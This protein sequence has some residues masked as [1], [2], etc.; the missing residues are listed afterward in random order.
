[1]ASTS[2]SSRSRASTLGADGSIPNLSEAVA[3]DTTS[4][5]TIT[6]T[7]VTATPTTSSPGATGGPRPVLSAVEPDDGTLKC[8]TVCLPFSGRG[9]WQD[10]IRRVANE[11][12]LLVTEKVRNN[13]ICL[14]MQSYEWLEQ[15]PQ[16]FQKSNC[17][18]S[19]YPGMGDLCEKCNQTRWLRRVEQLLKGPEDK[20][21]GKAAAATTSSKNSGAEYYEDED[22]DEQDQENGTSAEGALA[23]NRDSTFVLS[24]ATTAPFALQKF[25]PKSYVWPED[26]EQIQ[27][28]LNKKK[29]LIVKPEDGS[30]GD[31]IFLIDKFRDLELKASNCKAAVVQSYVKS[32]LLL[33]GFKFDLRVY[34]IVVGGLFGE[35]VKPRV[36]LCKDG[37]GRFCTEKYEKP[38]AKN[39][40]NSQKHLTNYSIQKRQAG[41]VR[42]GDVLVTTTESA[43]VVVPVSRAA[44]AAPAKDDRASMSPRSRISHSPAEHKQTVVDE[45][46]HN[47]G[48]TC[49]PDA[50][51]AVGHTTDEAGSAAA[52]EPQEVK[53]SSEREATKRS[54]EITLEQ[55]A[56]EYPDTFDE[57]EFW[58]Q[59]SE[60][61]SQWVTVMTPVLLASARPFEM[62]QEAAG[63]G[64]GAVGREDSKNSSS[65]CR[66]LQILGFD[67][68]LDQKMKMHLLEVNNSPS[69]SIDEV[70]PIAT[71]ITNAG[72]AAGAVVEQS[73][74]KVKPC[75]CMEHHLP[76][77]HHEGPVD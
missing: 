40:T 6:G 64:P 44:A 52:E 55:L 17:W 42:E 56:E 37:L 36:F 77:T 59:L 18:L 39:M 26:G 75:R 38:N 4:A 23:G 32:P 3:V 72:A 35:E 60:V 62:V 54:L 28:V 16:V 70:I 12:G 53:T 43:L 49:P 24:S 20:I 7:A 71:E 50:S 51:R 1:M 9:H 45:V 63:R 10:L 2:A 76:H 19:R 25:I 27:R 5:G 48:S 29:T 13:S 66:C 47:A 8:W 31:G 69:L 46:V 67:V 74:V 14:V 15:L 73:V 22:D 11:I 34:A 21:E 57:E 65:S 30:Q 33:N 61:V 41:Y 58:E 68:L